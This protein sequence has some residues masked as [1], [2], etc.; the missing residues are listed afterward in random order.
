MDKAL[1][2]LY[3][4]YLQTTASHADLAPSPTF[5][6]AIIMFSILSLIFVFIFLRT[7]LKYLATL[8]ASLVVGVVASFHGC[9]GGTASAILN[10]TGPIKSTPP[11]SSA[12]LD[13]YFGNAESNSTTPTIPRVSVMAPSINRR[14]VTNLSSENEGGT[15]GG[16][17]TDLAVESNLK[18]FLIS[19]SVQFNSLMGKT[20]RDG[21]SF[22]YKESSDEV[23]AK[24]IN[25]QNASTRNLVMDLK[26]DPSTSRAP[27]VRA[28]HGHPFPLL[29]SCISSDTND[30]RMTVLNPEHLEYVVTL[31]PNAPINIYSA[32]EKLVD[33]PGWFSP[34][35]IKLNEQT[36]YISDAKVRVQLAS[37]Q[38][39]ASGNVVLNNPPYVD[40]VVYPEGYNAKMGEFNMPTFLTDNRQELIRGGTRD[41]LV[42]P[43]TGELI[44][45]HNDISYPLR[46]TALGLH[47]TRTYRSFNAR[48][49]DFG[50]NWDFVPSREYYTFVTPV[51]TSGNYEYLRSGEGRIFYSGRSWPEDSTSAAPSASNVGPFWDAGDPFKPI[52][53]QTKLFRGLENSQFDL[54]GRLVRL[55]DKG[56][57]NAVYFLYEGNGLSLMMDQIA[58][59]NS[60]SELKSIVAAFQNFA[61]N[62]TSATDL[63]G[64]KQDS[65]RDAV[66]SKKGNFLFLARNSKGYVRVAVDKS[67]NF[68]WYTYDGV[69]EN[70]DRLIKVTRYTN[71]NPLGNAALQ[72]DA[73]D[74][75][76]YEYVPPSTF[77]PA[78]SGLLTS[79]SDHRQSNVI[80]NVNYVRDAGLYGEAPVVKAYRLGPLTYNFAYRFNQMNGTLLQP[81]T[82]VINDLMGEENKTTYIFNRIGVPIKILGPSETQHNT[83]LY[84]AKWDAQKMR[85][86]NLISRK[87]EM[88]LRF[89]LNGEPI[90]TDLC[91]EREGT[92]ATG[93]EIIPVLTDAGCRSEK[94]SIT[95]SSPHFQLDWFMDLSGSLIPLNTFLPTS[96]LN[97]NTLRSMT[98]ES[99]KKACYGGPGF[100]N[101]MDQGHGS[102]CTFI[103][104]PKGGNILKVQSLDTFEDGLTKSELDP[105]GPT[106][107]GLMSD[108]NTFISML[109]PLPPKIAFDLTNQSGFYNYLPGSGLSRR[110]EPGV[111]FQPGAYDQLKD[112]NPNSK[113]TTFYDPYGNVIASR[114]PWGSETINYYDYRLP[115]PLLVATNIR[116]SNDPAGDVSDWSH[117]RSAY[118]AFGNSFNEVRSEIDTYFMGQEAKYQ[119]YPVERI[120]DSK[121][122]ISKEFSLGQ[123]TE[124]KYGD[125]AAAPGCDKDYL[126]CSVVKRRRLQAVNASNLQK[127]TT[128]AYDGFDRIVETTDEDGAVIK[129]SYRSDFDHGVIGSEIDQSVLQA[130]TISNKI[131]AYD[132][133]GRVTCQKTVRNI[134]NSNL[135]NE[136]QKFVFNGFGEVV[137]EHKF[138]DVDPGITTCDAIAF[139]LMTSSVYTRDRSTGVVKKV[140]VRKIK[141]SSEDPGNVDE[142][143]YTKSYCGFDMYLKP[144]SILDENRGIYTKYSVDSENRLISSREMTREIYSGESYRAADYTC[145]SPPSV[146]Q[147]KEQERF[148]GCGNAIFTR[149]FTSASETSNP[150]ITSSEVE[151]DL[152][153]VKSVKDPR[154]WK[155]SFR[156]SKLGTLMGVS[157]VDNGED[158]SGHETSASFNLSYVKCVADGPTQTRPANGRCGTTG[159][160]HSL[161]ISAGP[162]PDERGNLHGGNSNT[163]SSWPY[164]FNE[165]TTKLTNALGVDVRTKEFIKSQKIITKYQSTTDLF[166]VDSVGPSAVG[167]LRKRLEPTFSSSEHIES[168]SKTISLLDSG[169]GIPYRSLSTFK[170]PISGAN[171][172]GL[173]KV[174][175]NTLGQ[176]NQ[177]ATYVS[178]TSAFSE[179]SEPSATNLVEQVII[180]GRF[181]GATQSLTTERVLPNNLGT[182][183]EV[184]TN[185]NFIGELPMSS[186]IQVSGVP[187]IGGSGIKNDQYDGV[188]VPIVTEY[189]ASPDRV[190]KNV[191]LTTKMTITRDLA[192][193]IQRYNLNSK[194]SIGPTQQ[195]NPLIYQP[196]SRP[197]NPIVNRDFYPSAGENLNVDYTYTNEGFKM[198]YD[199][200]TVEYKLSRGGI[201]DGAIQSILV[202]VPGDSVKHQYRNVGSTEPGATND[203][204]IIG[205]HVSEQPF[206]GNIDEKAGTIDTILPTGWDLPD[207][208]ARSMDGIENL[209]RPE[210]TLYFLNR[211]AIPFRVSGSLFDYDNEIF[212]NMKLGFSSDGQAA[213][214]QQIVHLYEYLQPLHYNLGANQSYLRMLPGSLESLGGAYE[215]A[216]YTKQFTSLSSL[217]NYQAE[218]A[219]TTQGLRNF[220]VRMKSCDQL[221]IGTDIQNSFTHGRSKWNDDASPGVNPDSITRFNELGKLSYIKR[222][223]YYK[224]GSAD[225]RK[226]IREVKNIYDATGSLAGQEQLLSYRN[227]SGLNAGS[228]EPKLLRAILSRYHNVIFP[229]PSAIGGLSNPTLKEVVRDSGSTAFEAGIC[230]PNVLGEKP[231]PDEC[232]GLGPNRSG[233]WYYIPGPSGGPVMAFRKENDGGGSC[234]SGLDCRFRRYDVIYD[235]MGNVVFF[236]KNDADFYQK[237]PQSKEI[238]MPYGGSVVIR[239]KNATP[240]YDSSFRV[241][242]FST[243]NNYMD[244]TLA[245]NSMDPEIQPN[246]S[247]FSYRGSRRDI[248]GNVY[249]AEGAYDPFYAQNLSPTTDT[250]QICRGSTPALRSTTNILASFRGS[251]SGAA[252]GSIRKGSFSP[253]I[254]KFERLSSEYLDYLENHPSAGENSMIGFYANY[255]T[256]K[257][258]SDRDSLNVLWK[259]SEP[260]GGGGRW[261]AGNI[262]VSVLDPLVLS[263]TLGN[264]ADGHYARAAFHI[265]GL[266]AGPLAKTF[267]AFQEA[268]AL[269]AGLKAGTSLEGISRVGR[270]ASAYES[271]Y[272][273]STLIND[274][275]GIGIIE[276]GD[277]E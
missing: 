151:D 166:Q 201:S 44:L 190:E 175:L 216:Q 259:L 49:G 103:N 71:H 116:Y 218:P 240:I 33:Y 212:R 97:N 113:L 93:A 115:T 199:G 230:D 255:A 79:V 57:G 7:N 45:S 271:L 121:M 91:S 182:L 168:G 164:I 19:D 181:K 72:Y 17:I 34:I 144:T 275:T 65:L 119:Q 29:V 75:Y 110:F 76:R 56:T 217:L 68:N 153:L 140:E 195:E 143:T 9:G 118:D 221:M 241:V 64:L 237:A 47:L 210:S 148:D 83:V 46:D 180:N 92:G 142:E 189:S 86:T 109:S 133:H 87:S 120:L 104:D 179:T 269:S 220:G 6:P 249:L 24:L 183:R 82:D 234:S 146:L 8:N 264:I 50:W 100:F 48:V 3:A 27:V 171:Q 129:T 262:F 192:N 73:L 253:S 273:T 244:K 197:E 131:L 36:N 2:Q 1:Q 37:V 35:F 202:T 77:G 159:Y 245:R 40:I 5:L 250:E 130:G 203:P 239:Y 260:I 127:V 169:F 174:S 150:V 63:Q 128:F 265:A 54:S 232:Q 41:G 78:W 246:E 243:D 147:S 248:I 267:S 114:H 233:T 107:D 156:Y 13:N 266:M 18:P 178:K 98:A 160:I 167:T 102:W 219:P 141:G 51:G 224:R 89:D 204:L 274:L 211:D 209:F 145:D 138:Y 122:R 161:D 111:P 21:Q 213:R 10:P 96:E 226:W 58:A 101:Y 172:Y 155:S 106:T 11:P 81:Q 84:E 176:S 276:N 200:F 88:V 20:I 163:P 225:E 263:L 12:D 177:S 165:A 238:Y 214:L 257:F 60:Q 61:S 187:F 251:R 222:A 30:T 231:L 228:P 16:T 158:I 254:Q 149:R 38:S 112:F 236:Y 252:N 125:S 247:P 229:L 95:Y 207:L 261:S 256:W 69:Q 55:Y 194:D 132:S 170:D 157:D 105:V 117:I 198:A 184:L 123:E 85:I 43:A 136:A 39:F 32:V 94:R 208:F 154:G 74:L 242:R 31:P 188:G 90:A 108:L 134:P 66:L 152:C 215:E 173:V 62:A 186:D 258:F 196:G 126:L 28:S 235:L 26:L 205:D 99:T 135:K 191:A 185:S 59:R 139:R 270:T 206:P 137:E 4:N 223:D 193:R 25:C 23:R 227:N 124:F 268:R 15:S 52:F 277:G 70:G 42:N 67:A 162:G 22:T 53:N 14:N 80:S 272:N